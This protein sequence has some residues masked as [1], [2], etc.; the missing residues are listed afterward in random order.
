MILAACIQ[1]S[2]TVN[3]CAS[4]HARAKNTQQWWIP[5]IRMQRSAW[6]ILK[7]AHTHT[8]IRSTERSWEE[9][10]FFLLN[11]RFTQPSIRAKKRTEKFEVLRKFNVS[12]TH[13]SHLKIGRRNKR[14]KGPLRPGYIRGWN[15]KQWIKRW[16]VLPSTSAEN[17]TEK[18]CKCC[19]AR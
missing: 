17:Q 9:V 11:Q 8:H 2:W 14:P 19:A 6:R 1:D 12:R 18:N 10:P 4:S 16:V 3:T 13:P 15:S 7:H 5:D